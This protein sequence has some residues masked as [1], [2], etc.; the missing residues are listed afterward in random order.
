MQQQRMFPG[1][2]VDQT[3]IR[4]KGGVEAD[5]TGAELALGDT[6]TLTIVGHVTAA[7]VVLDEKLEQTVRHFVM[8][9]DTV[10]LHAD[11]DAK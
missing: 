4:V 10:K 9:A 1:I 5:Y 8:S 3:R 2:K 7:G 11:E 6:V